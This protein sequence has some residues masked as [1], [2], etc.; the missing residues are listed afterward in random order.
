MRHFN[1]FFSYFTNTKIIMLIWSFSNNLAFGLYPSSTGLTLALSKGP[2]R[3]G[4]TPSPPPFY[5]KT[6]AQP[7][8]ET[9]FFN[10][11]TGR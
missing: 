8:S 1:I 10:K 2:H 6:E 11:N 3:V 7:V 4:A 5:L 9:S